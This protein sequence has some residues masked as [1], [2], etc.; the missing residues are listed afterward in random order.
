MRREL[1]SRITPLYRWVI[2]S[3]LTIAAVL[4]IWRLGRVG[5][6]GRPDVAAVILAVAI[7]AGLIFLARVL[8]KGKTVWIDGET[9]I[10]ADH[11]T[12]IR[13][14]L[15]DIKSADTTRFIKPDRVRVRFSRPTKFGDSI[16]FFPPSH[17]FRF[18]LRHPLAAELE[19]LAAEA[20]HTDE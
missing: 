13:V 8:D 17:W 11:R 4:V 15:S 20:R 5:M 16:V 7:A 3:I 2:P 6:P 12:E 19:R 9:L 10:V 1:S 18:S 14:N